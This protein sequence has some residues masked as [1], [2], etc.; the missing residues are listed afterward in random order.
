[1]KKNGGPLDVAQEAHSHSHPF[2]RPFD[3]ARD[4]GDHERFT[5]PVL[6]NAEMGD[7][8]RKRVICDLGPGG[9][10][11]GDEGRFAD[12]REA[13]DSDIGQELEFQRDPALLTRDAGLGEARG[14]AGSGG[15]PRVAAATHSALRDD[16]EAPVGRQIGE[17]V[18]RIR[19]PDER[20]HRN[21]DFHILGILARPLASFAVTAV[22]GHVVLAELEIEEGAPAEGGAEDHIS[23]MAAVAAVRSS[24][25]DEL[26]PPEADA[27]ASTVARLDVNLRLVDEFHYAFFARRGWKEK[28]SSICRVWKQRLRIFP[29]GSKEERA[30]AA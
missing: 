13:D 14:L 8:R 12:I 28:M 6:D 11:A 24:A 17:K 22:F 19:V 1:M 3:Q 4:V 2:V 25:G 16:E 10:D 26:L 30:A 18:P 5:F 20:A 9:G 7:E 23:P 15:E 29:D 21:D 27:A